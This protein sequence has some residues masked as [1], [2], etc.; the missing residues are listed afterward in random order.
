ME[1]IERVI[2]TE[3]DETR[4]PEGRVLVTKHGELSCVNMY[5]PNGSSGPERQHYKD[6]WLEDMLEWSQK[7]IDS[8]EPSLLCGDL[9]IAHT[10]DD[11]WN[12]TG[13]RGTSGFL[14]QERAWFDRLLESGWNDLLRTSVGPG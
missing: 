4:D 3:L 9:N 12:P 2:D 10:E 14:P 5:L 7:F 6:Q 8:S 11:I 1:E 13:N